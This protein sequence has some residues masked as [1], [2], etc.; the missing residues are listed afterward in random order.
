MEA[1]ILDP[2]Y[3][4]LAIL[5]SF[6][7]FI[8][9]ERYNS[10]GDFEILLPA[11]LPVREF[12]VRKNYIYR[13]GTKT[14]ME[15]ED[16]EIDQ[17]VEDGDHMIITGR[18]LEAILDRR[19][20]WGKRIFYG[21]LQ[22]AI[23]SL[24]LESVINP[25]N[26][27]RKIPNFT[28]KLSNDPAITNL[29]IYAELLGDNLY[30]VICSWCSER[31]IGFRILPQGEG[32][33]EFSLY[34]GKDRSYD[35][36]S[37]PWVVFSPKYD[38]FLS[39]NYFES[40]RLLKTDAYVRAEETRYETTDDGESY[41]Y[42]IVREEAVSGETEEKIGLDRREMYVD[43]GRYSDD[44]DVISQMQQ[45]GKEALSETNTTKTF[46]GEIDASIQYIYGEDFFI[47]DVVQVVNAYGKEAS[48]RIVEI[49]YSHDETG[50][51]VTP[52]FSGL[53]TND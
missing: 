9:T 44:G 30:D 43:V 14:L 38:N 3:E 23:R 51:R 52:T 19:I 39:S 8:W 24:L 29:T 41:S 31:N 32:G 16:I 20:V 27:S 46:E 4:S 1:I 22:N 37:L 42:T 28:F 7:S 47:G 48:S 25:T 26:P 36:D 21:S 11:N 33:F 5:D 40:E 17:N 12:L 13:K 18:S 6:Q 2:K 53:L 45:D 34:A 10:A 35:Q 49:V 50:E 15:I